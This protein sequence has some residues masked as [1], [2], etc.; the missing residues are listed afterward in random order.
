[1]SQRL[2]DL[3]E[4][5]KYMAEYQQRTVRYQGDIAAALMGAISQCA[6]RLQITKPLPVLPE[7]DAPPPP[8]RPPADEEDH[9][10]EKADEEGQEEE[11]PAE[12]GQGDEEVDQDEGMDGGDE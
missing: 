5:V 7:F 1:M 11:G 8:V 4:Q 9:E 12:A 10:E 2:T 6:S 3:E